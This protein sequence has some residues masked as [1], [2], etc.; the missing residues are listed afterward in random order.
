MAMTA[1]V[2][3]YCLQHRFGTKTISIEG[4]ERACINCIWYDPYFHENRGNISARVWS[5]HGWCIRQGKQR[6]ALGRPCK[7]Y[8]TK[9][10]PRP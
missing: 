3:S 8:E 1:K 4:S 5:S 9:E 7:D 10:S 2:E 6:G